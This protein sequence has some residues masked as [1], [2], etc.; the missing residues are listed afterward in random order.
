M[1]LMIAGPL[2]AAVGEVHGVAIGVEKSGEAH[3]RFVPGVVSSLTIGT[4]GLR[5]RMCSMEHVNHEY[6]PPRSENQRA[7][8]ARL[9]G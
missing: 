5:F 8:G 6:A 9:N 3:H 4:Q 7:V 2:D 1:V